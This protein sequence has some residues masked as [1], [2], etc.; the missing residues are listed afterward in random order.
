SRGFGTDPGAAEKFVDGVA[1]T[2]P[3]DQMGDLTA[4]AS[5]VPG[6]SVTASGVS[7]FGLGPSANTTT[8]NGMSFAGSDVPRE[9]RT[10]TRVTTST[11]DPSRGWFSG[12]NTNVDLAGGNLLATK[13][14]SFT[15]DAPAAQYTDPVSAHLG[16]RYTN[17]RV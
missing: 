11:Y 15:V 4:A 6:L 7:A 16:Q 17:V 5:T 1:S 12:A 14:A 2:I 13:R 9:A 10:S 3:P 8:L